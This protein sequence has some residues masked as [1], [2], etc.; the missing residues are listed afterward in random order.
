M[1]PVIV[2]CPVLKA[3]EAA[4]AECAGSDL[5]LDLTSYQVGG[6][7]TSSKQKMFSSAPSDSGQ[8]QISPLFGDSKHKQ[9]GV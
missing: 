8:T 5:S 7:S 6:C 4:Q 2:R 9:T 1:V 3:C